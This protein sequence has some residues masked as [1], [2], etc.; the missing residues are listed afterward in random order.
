[1]S[2]CQQICTH[3]FFTR[4][5]HYECLRMSRHAMSNRFDVV[6]SIIPWRH[7]YLIIARRPCLLNRTDSY[8]VLGKAH[9]PASGSA[10]WRSGSESSRLRSC[11][12]G[13]VPALRRFCVEGQAIRG[14][15][16]INRVLWIQRL[17]SAEPTHCCC[18]CP[19]CLQVSS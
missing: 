1:M 11:P 10:R 13:S 8:V 3:D 4:M 2:W 6:S 12:F 18:C 5:N 9:P 7:V 14:Y 15:R 19:G 17:D 16:L